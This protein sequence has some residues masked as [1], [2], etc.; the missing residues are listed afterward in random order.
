MLYVVVYSDI[1]SGY[2]AVKGVAT[3]PEAAFDIMTDAFRLRYS[4]DPY[5]HKR[6]WSIWSY[7]LLCEWI[8]PVYLHESRG[9]ILGSQVPQLDPMFG[10][11]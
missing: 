5:C 1:H 4:C 7:S 3:T 9:A 6:D 10:M 2:D 11:Y 8:Y